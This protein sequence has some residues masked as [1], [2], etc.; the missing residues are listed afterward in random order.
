MASFVTSA[1]SGYRSQFY[2]QNK[3]VKMLYILKQ[4]E[5]QRSE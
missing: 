4:Y 2:F 3:V 1:T 5:I